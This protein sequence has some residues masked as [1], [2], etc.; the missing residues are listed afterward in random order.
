MAR[1]D[2]AQQ[3]AKVNEIG[4]RQYLPGGGDGRYTS[5][6]AGTADAVIGHVLI[7]HGGMPYTKYL[8]SFSSTVPVGDLSL[9]EGMVGGMVQS[10]ADA[11]LLRVWTDGLGYAHVAPD[12]FSPYYDGR[13]PVFA[14]NRS[15]FWDD[16]QIEYSEGNKVA[17][18]RVIARDAYSLRWYDE[19]YPAV[20]LPYGEIV[21]IKDLIVPNKQA[22]RD[23]AK[24][25]F[26]ASGSLRS[27]RI[28]TGA[29][30]FLQP[31]DRHTVTLP[32]IDL[33][34]GAEN[35]NYYVAG[36]DIDISRERWGLNWRTSIDMQ[37]LPMSAPADPD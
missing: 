21:M 34:G 31:W 20:P 6:T 36:Y 4:A 10:V 2:G 14:W 11:A 1:V 33:G 24:R 23:R 9:S 5:H 28:P 18:V 17:Q 37:E 27:I 19:V 16:P 25:Q 35:V 8:R 3:R 15:H 26:Y 30:P 32:G 22:A 13:V 29:V 7:Q 12:P